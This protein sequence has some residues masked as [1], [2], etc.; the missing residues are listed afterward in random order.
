M[1]GATRVKFIFRDYP[2]RKI[3]TS[4]FYP[5]EPFVR[6]FKAFKRRETSH[7]YSLHSLSILNIMNHF[8]FSLFSTVLQ[9]ITHS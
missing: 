2:R 9:R 7:F 4:D 8:A 1:C 3:M 6:I 5:S